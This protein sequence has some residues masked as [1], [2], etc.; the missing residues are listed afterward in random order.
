MRVDL[1]EKFLTQLKTLSYNT[2]SIRNLTTNNE[3]LTN[4]N[5]ELEKAINDIKEL[6]KDLENTNKTSLVEV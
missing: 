4:K 6:V 2:D 1:E 3:D 5:K